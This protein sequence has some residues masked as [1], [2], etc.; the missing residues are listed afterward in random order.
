[1]REAEPLFQ[2]HT[3][4][5]IDWASAKISDVKK[6]SPYCAAG[7]LAVAKAE[8]RI[9]LALVS[10]C[11]SFF[12]TRRSEWCC[13]STFNDEYAAHLFA[14]WYTAENME[15]ILWLFCEQEEEAS[16]SRIQL[17]FKT[18][19][20][21]SHALATH[22]S[23]IIVT[24][25]RIFSSC[26]DNVLSNAHRMSSQSLAAFP[27]KWQITVCKWHKPLVLYHPYNTIGDVCFV[28]APSG[29]LVVFYSLLIESCETQ[30]AAVE[31][32]QTT[33][34]VT[35]QKQKSCLHTL[36]H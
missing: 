26:R 30:F 23:V 12:G 24:F 27:I 1:M 9:C 29:Q 36:V 3:Q 10:G 34:R 2:L 32:K 8:S 22:S 21:L 25:V 18:A 13:S 35:N 11:G 7:R 5:H 4:W 17:L 15:G 33:D 31:C 28:G 16:P 6:C 14:T 20:I 19:S